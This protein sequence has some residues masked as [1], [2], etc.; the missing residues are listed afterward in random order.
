MLATVIR[1]TPNDAERFVLLRMWMLTESPWA[2]ASTPEDDDALDLAHVRTVLGQ[3][4]NAIVAVESVETL[5]AAAGIFRMKSPKFAHRAKLWGVFV[6]P[7]H[8]GLGLGRAVTTA[9]IDLAKRWRGIDF[10]DLG[11]RANS[12]EAQQLYG[13]LGFK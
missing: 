4:E 9:A 5:I 11:V 2:F 3:N 10:I 12:P 8:R 7:S 13:S 6:D 1:L